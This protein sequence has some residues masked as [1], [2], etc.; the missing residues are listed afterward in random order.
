[1]EALPYK[2][3]R[4]FCHR[5]PRPSKTNQYLNKLKKQTLHGLYQGRGGCHNQAKTHANHV[6]LLLFS[7]TFQENKLPFS[8][9]CG[10][11]RRHVPSRVGITP[12]RGGTARR[13]SRS[14]FCCDMRQ[15]RVRVSL[16]PRIPRQRAFRHL[17]NLKKQYVRAPTQNK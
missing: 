6:V 7:G 13:G 2:K 5:S 17:L 15:A 1:M 10:T 12:T 11:Q 14:P 8:F 3:K 16:R 9:R 4:H